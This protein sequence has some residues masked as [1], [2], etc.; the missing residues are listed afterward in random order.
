MDMVALSEAEHGSEENISC[1][2][3]EWNTL[4]LY[5]YLRLL[6]LLWAALYTLHCPTQSHTSRDCDNF[7]SV[8]PALKMDG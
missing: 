2:V 3:Q 6:Q 5:G 4:Q 8:S 1:P 7:I